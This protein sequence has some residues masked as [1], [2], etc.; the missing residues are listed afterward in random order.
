ML[1]S[2]K[3]HLPPLFLLAIMILPLNGC[4]DPGDERFPENLQT[5]H[6]EVPG[7]VE[8]LES[9]LIGDWWQLAFQCPGDDQLIETSANFMLRF[10]SDHSLEVWI[11]S[12]IVSNHTW[13]LQEN[14]GSPEII[15]DPPVTRTSEQFALCYAPQPILRFFGD[16]RGCNQFFGHKEFQP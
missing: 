4:D 16:N 3:T 7:N 5:C 11:E 13:A 10:I 8:L 1:Q 6:M 14:A 12:S 2:L 9:V 15:I